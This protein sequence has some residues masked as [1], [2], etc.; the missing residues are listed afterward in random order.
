MVTYQTHSSAGIYEALPFP[1]S[2][3]QVEERMKVGAAES[4]FGVIS[5]AAMVFYYMVTYFRAG[6]RMPWSLD[7][8]D[9]YYISMIHRVVHHTLKI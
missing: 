2:Q 6:C 1:A 7:V 8:F 4:N 5:E 9:W 3:A